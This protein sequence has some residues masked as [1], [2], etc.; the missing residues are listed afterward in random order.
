LH[1]IINELNDFRLGFCKPLKYDYTLF[2]KNKFAL[3]D[4]NHDVFTNLGYEKYD[5]QN[6][7]DVISSYLNYYMIIGKTQYSW[8]GEK[9]IFEFIYFAI[10]S[11]IYNPTFMFAFYDILYN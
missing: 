4:L 3:T 7:D 2:E 10:K 9:M 11:S 6:F 5:F 1:L 8:K